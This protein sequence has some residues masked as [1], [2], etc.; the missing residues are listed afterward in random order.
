MEGLKREDLFV[1]VYETKRYKTS[2]TAG[3]SPKEYRSD[4]KLRPFTV[5]S[6]ICDVEKWKTLAL[7]LAGDS[8]LS[9]DTRGNA[10]I[11]AMRLKVLSLRFR[12]TLTTIRRTRVF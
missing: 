7:A 2:V 11:D 12:E 10:N 8:H 1:Y 9:D 5:E 6:L 4:G 3:N